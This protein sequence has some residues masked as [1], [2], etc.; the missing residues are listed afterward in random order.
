[1]SVLLCFL[2]GVFDHLLAKA[3]LKDD[4]LHFMLCTWCETGP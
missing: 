2:V 3:L 1:M 4:D